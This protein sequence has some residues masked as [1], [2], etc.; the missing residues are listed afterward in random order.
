MPEVFKIGDL[1]W[2]KMKGFPPWPGKVSTPPADIASKKPKKPSS[3]IYFFGSR[4][5]AW[6]EDNFI[7][8]YLEHK[9]T[10]EKSNKSVAFKEACAAIEDF[11]AKGEVMDEAE[12]EADAFVDEA[13]ALFNKIKEESTAPATPVEK[14]KPKPKSTKKEYNNTSRGSKRLSENSSPAG[15]DSVLHSIKKKKQRL[16]S[17]VS[18]SPSLRENS[19]SGDDYSERLSYS[20]KVGLLARP[21][22]TDLPATPSLDLTSINES[23]KDKNINPSSLKF[24]FLGLGI[25]GS[26]IVKNLLNSGHSVIVWNRSPEKKFLNLKISNELMVKDSTTNLNNKQFDTSGEEDGS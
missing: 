25:M 12:N 19:R 7:K 2:A 18:G 8:S 21:A 13:D 3:C 14:P 22:N 20:P 15:A 1:V 4:N 5:Y 17:S 26:G 11:I 9:E 16:S 10:L 6:I 24:G 23:L